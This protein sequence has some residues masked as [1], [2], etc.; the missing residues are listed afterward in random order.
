[1]DLQELLLAREE[2]AKYQT[3]LLRKYQAPLVCL[4]LNIPG[5]EKNNKLITKASLLAERKLK[6]RFPHML[7][8]EHKILPTGC[9]GY[10]VIPGD[11]KAIKATCME[12]ESIPP[13][14]RLLDLDVLIPA[15]EKLSREKPRSCLLCGEDARVCRRSGKHPIEELANKALDLLGQAVD[16]DF[17]E[18]VSSLAVQSLLYELLTTPK[19]GLVDMENSGSHKDMDVFTFAASASALGSFFRKCCKAGCESRGTEAPALLPKLRYLGR[20]GEA[21]MYRATVGVN[22]HKGAIFSLGLLCAAAGRLADLSDPSALCIEAAHIVKDITRRELRPLT[23]ET[24]QSKGEKLYLSHGITGIRGQAERGFPTILNIGLP[25]LRE[26]LKQGY[27][28][29]RSGTAALLAMLKDEADTA[30]ISRSSPKRYQALR[31]ELADLLRKDPYPTADTIRALDQSF[32]AE[33]LSPGGSADLLA[34]THF[35]HLGSS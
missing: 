22:T 5:P 29:H 27:D 26:G 1:M 11:S 21:T 2:R 14:G 19:P 10:Y 17:S 23:R 33:N 16:E 4:T 7:H 9:E 13:L 18:T 31:Q 3:E 30:L 15:G 24:A 12:L 32:I 35:L 25:T 6:A 34:L 28:L 20:E 8:E